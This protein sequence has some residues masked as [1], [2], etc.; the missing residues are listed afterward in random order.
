MKSYPY[1]SARGQC[2]VRP[3]KGFTLTELIV[4]IAILA[5]LV[6]IASPSFSRLIEDR[7]VASQATALRTALSLA[8]SEALKRGT[9]VAVTANGGNFSNGWCVHIN[10][11]CTGVNMIRVDGA[12]TRVQVTATASASTIVFNR[13]GGRQTPAVDVALQVQPQGGCV[14]GSNGRRVIEVGLSGRLTVRRSDCT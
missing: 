8:R 9:P 4:T 14:A 5:I 1:V 13:R 3:P 11:D 12:A 7:R 10:A 6:S 2:P